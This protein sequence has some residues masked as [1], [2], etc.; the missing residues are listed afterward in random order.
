LVIYQVVITA[1]LAMLLLNTIN[2]LHLLRTPRAPLHREDHEEEPLISILV[3]ARNEARSI[4]DCV[5]SLAQ[6][7]YPHCEILVLDDQSEDQTAAIVTQLAS[8]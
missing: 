6:Q 3:P 1:T 7:D 8:R 5:E 4:A 2:N